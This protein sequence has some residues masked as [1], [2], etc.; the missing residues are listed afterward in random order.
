MSGQFFPFNTR[1]KFT[2]IEYV[3]QMYYS[4]TFLFFAVVIT[5]LAA[6]NYVLCT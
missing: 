3:T 6:I 5:L 4:Q 1:L 2:D